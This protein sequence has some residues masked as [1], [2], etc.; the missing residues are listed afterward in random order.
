MTLSD[1]IFDVDETTFET[2]VLMRSHEVPVVV[3]FWAPWCGPCKIVGPTL[4]RLTIEAGGAIRL[5]KVNVD[6]NPQLA[7][8][9]GVQG[10][11]AIKAFKNGDVEAEF[12]G[13]QPEPVLRRFIKN[14]APS[15]AEKAVEKA[16]S[17]LVTRH[18]PE[19]ENAFRAVLDQDDANA[20]A[21]LGLVESYLM[22]GK[23][24]AALRLIEHFP[25][26]TEWATAERLRP[27]AGL[28]AQVEED[29]PRMAD[30]PLEASFFQAARLIAKGN[31]QGAMDGLLEILRQ[32]KN[33]RDGLP[34]QVMLA[35]FTLLGDDD[36][37]TREYRDELASVLF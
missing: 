22:Q 14:L 37:V 33:Y 6:H 8:R 5:A 18:W 21:A 4:E 13:A 12:V 3:D 2:E 30:D 1:Y 31:F 24:S 15:E 17:L 11:P 19:A 10:I 7:I 20:S 28:I 35:L 25:S 29:G 34:K 36:P 26:G 16:R 27:L 9:Y 32:D 23:G